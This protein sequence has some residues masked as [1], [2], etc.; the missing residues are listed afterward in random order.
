MHR[1]RFAIPSLFVLAAFCL[2]P[3]SALANSTLSSK[4]T[5]VSGNNVGIP[6]L[7]VNA[8]SFS[9]IT[10]G[11]QAESLGLSGASPD[12]GISLNAP[13]AGP[14][15]RNLVL[16]EFAI[17]APPPVPEP[18]TLTLFATGLFSLAGVARRKLGKG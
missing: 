9:T 18:A 7:N 5:G 2:W 1:L 17:L 3:G 4:L 15:S 6:S 16:R 13:M 10:Q 11:G 14:H 12:G 8:G